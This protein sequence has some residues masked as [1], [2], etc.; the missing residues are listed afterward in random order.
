VLV[1]LLRRRF[2]ARLLAQQL[3]LD[4][5]VHRLPGERELHAI[6]DAAL[7]VPLLTHPE[8]ISLPGLKAGRQD[9]KKKEI[10]CRVPE[11]AS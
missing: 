5:E 7:L 2:A 3:R 6:A 1:G 9:K 10:P 11:R 8:K 4:G